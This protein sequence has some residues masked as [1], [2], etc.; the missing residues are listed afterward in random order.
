MTSFLFQNQSPLFAGFNNGPSQ[1]PI[2]LALFDFT[3]TGVTTT[4]TI[5][6]M[7]F[8]FGTSYTEHVVPG[9]PQL[10]QVPEPASLLLLGSG[11][12]GMGAWRWKKSRV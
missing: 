8:N 3:V 4:S 1:F 9:T 6:S 12:A 7:N 11:L 2:G 10:Q 5:T